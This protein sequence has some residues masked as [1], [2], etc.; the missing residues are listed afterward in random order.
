MSATSRGEA[1]SV[2]GGASNRRSRHRCPSI[3]IVDCFLDN[4]H[5]SS[6][7]S[8]QAATRNSIVSDADVPRTA[9]DET[10]AVVDRRR[11]VRRPRT[12]KPTAFRSSHRDTRVGWIAHAPVGI[13]FTRRRI[14]NPQRPVSM[15]VSTATNRFVANCRISRTWRAPVVGDRHWVGD[16]NRYSK[17]RGS[18]ARHGVRC[19]VRRLLAPPR[20]IR[21]AMAH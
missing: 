12:L 19:R 3:A 20:R 7:D 16:G 13:A 18:S 9:T 1:E 11:V 2:R 6:I 5:P 14:P 10:I 4:D 8:E 15:W 17:W 21:P